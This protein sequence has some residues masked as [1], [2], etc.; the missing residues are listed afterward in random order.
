MSA[1]SKP[2]SRRS[3]DPRAAAL[4]LLA[5]TAAAAQEATRLPDLTVTAA[6]RDLAA[7]ASP[8]AVRTLGNAT[9][10]DSAGL[11]L[12]DKLRAAPG[13]SLFR[14][15]SSLV[16][17]PAS[18]GVTLRGVAPGAVSRSLVLLDGVPL[19]D[20]FGGWVA[21]SAIPALDIARVEIVP[22]GGAALWGGGTLGGTVG[23]VTERIRGGSGAAAFTAGDFATVGFEAHA[24]AEDRGVAL[25]AG[26]RVQTTGGFPVVESGRR[27]P[28]DVPAGGEH[29]LGH[30]R[31]EAGLGAARLAVALRAFGEER[32]NGTPYTRNRSRSVAGSARLA[33]GDDAFR[34]EGAFQARR[35]DFAST[36]SAVD[37]ARAGETPSTDQTDVPSVAWGASLLGAWRAGPAGVQAGVEARGV[38][39]RTREETVFRD[40]RFTLLR[41]AGGRQAFAGA[42]L[43]GDWEAADGTFRVEG[44]ARADV[45]RNDGAFRRE[46]GLADGFVRLD[47]AGADDTGTEF[48]PRFGISWKPARGW[49]VRGAAYRAFRVPTLS[50]LHRPFRVGSVITEAN[51]ALRP[52]RSWGAEAGVDWTGAP[53]WSAAFTAFTIEVEDAVGSVT[54]AQGPGTFP[55]FGTLPAGVTGRQRQ[56]L[57][58]LRTR[59]VEADVA[60][61]SASGWR[62]E[63]AVFL[64]DAEVV[65][66]PAQPG[67]QGLRPLQTPGHVATAALVVPLGWDLTLR[68][69][70]RWTGAQY[71]DD[72]NRLLLAPA[73][74]WDVVL[75]WV[76]AAG[77]TVRASVENA[78]D[79]RVE[80]GRSVAGVVSVATP[81]LA[82]LRI[83]RVW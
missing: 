40:G 21:W 77:W 18:Q 1:R 2:T 72:E 17:N 37:A 80:S 32:G 60:W 20:P 51:A 8:L 46:S 81:R 68:N 28:V 66:A 14:R 41:E 76:P 27:G 79:A 24:D 75:G 26:G 12:D 29:R 10:A 3:P 33:G 7:D 34:W 65:A 62:A 49:R 47:T 38:E 82:S 15:S 54:L 58:R 43:L 71:E 61:A 36:F 6:R 25:R 30:A 22:G 67:L 48:S 35:A 23:V 55:L 44:A 56:N 73:V 52:E 70:V 78:A 39:G 5:A 13:V 45:W 11:Q 59:G 69:T 42:F 63:A 31:L 19:N 9:L 53:G 50:E 74:T 57:A 16:S 64:A 4:A 83:E